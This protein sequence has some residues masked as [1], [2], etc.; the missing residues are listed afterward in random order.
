MG[1]KKVLTVALIGVGYWGKNL[2]RVLRDL[3]AEVITVDGVG[4]ADYR[5]VGDLPLH[6]MD[7]AVVAT[8]P[9]THFEI[10]NF[11]L[12]HKIPLFVE[13]PLTISSESA[14]AL[15]DKAEAKKTVLCV[16]HTFIYNPALQILKNEIANPD[17]GKIM[18]IES[19]RQNLGLFS[20]Q[21]DVLWDLAPHDFSIILNI[22]GKPPLRISAKSYKHFTDFADTA[23]V[24]MEF[25]G[26]QT[27]SHL[28]WIYPIKVRRLTV[29]GEHRMVMWDDVD[30][31][32]KI[33]VF[34]KGAAFQ[35][36]GNFG[37]F[38]TSYRSGETR[39]IPVPNEEPLRLEMG[40]FLNCVASGETP[41]TS[42]EDG[43]RVVRLIEKCHE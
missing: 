5:G 34:D 29:I 25:D 22:I 1:A 39:I 17:F 10:A 2:L 8:P 21:S 24:V 31:V 43:L 23:E 33:W 15:V 18:Y 7:A 20:A 16:G 38:Q 27:F 36:S 11:L 37:E 35:P 26:C 19:T 9:H 6:E 12:D 28:S 42:G 30:N 3:H 41:L 14:K 4:R 40:H 32:N 13:K